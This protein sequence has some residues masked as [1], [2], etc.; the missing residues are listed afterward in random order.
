MDIMKVRDKHLP[1]SRL[2]LALCIT[3]VIASTICLFTIAAWTR[4]DYGIALLG[5]VS[6]SWIVVN[7]RSTILGYEVYIGFTERGNLICLWDPKKP[8][9]CDHGL[10]VNLSTCK[11]RWV[12]GSRDVEKLLAADSTI[13]LVNELDSLSFRPSYRWFVSDEKSLEALFEVE[14]PS[15]GR[16]YCTALDLCKIACAKIYLKV[17][18]LSTALKALDDHKQ[19]SSQLKSFCNVFCSTTQLRHTSEGRLLEIE[20]RKLERILDPAREAEID[21]HISRIQEQIRA[22]E[23]KG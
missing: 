18:K 13:R 4:V 5:C 17:P 19:L 9:S 20:I 7:F 6:L 1:K 16:L 21:Y 8:P 15:T 12:L 11:C 2:L 3:A 23:I 14:Y 22:G 10:V